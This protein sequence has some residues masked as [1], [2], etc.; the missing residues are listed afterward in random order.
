MVAVI[1]LAIM[2][3]ATVGGVLFDSSGYMST[4][5]ISAALLLMA[6][7]LATVASRV[8]VHQSELRPGQSY[9][10]SAS[11]DPHQCQ[12]ADEREA[13]RTRSNIQK[14]M[15]LCGTNLSMD[16]CLDSRKS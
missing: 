12:L 13:D 16:S 7:L 4:F 11:A 14:S 6:A 2:L 9:H 10:R 1:Q 3:G 8:S 5:A 15:Q